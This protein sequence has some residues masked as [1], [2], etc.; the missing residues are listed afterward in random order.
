[1]ILLPMAPKNCASSDAFIV[2][3]SLVSPRLP[4]QPDFTPVVIVR[5]PTEG[6]LTVAIHRL[7]YYAR[8]A[9]ALEFTATFVDSPRH[10]DDNRALAAAE[11]EHLGPEFHAAVTA[12]AIQRPQ[13]FE[14]SAHPHHFTRLQVK[15]H[16]RSLMITIGIPGRSRP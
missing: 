10:V 6:P 1:M 3:L 9:E 14:H 16:R 13:N 7:E 4:A 5:A 2:F 12:L 15:R 8:A 11:L